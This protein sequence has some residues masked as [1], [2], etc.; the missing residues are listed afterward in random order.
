[1]MDLD[2]D[3]KLTRAEITTFVHAELQKQG[4]MT[5]ITDEEEEEMISQILKIEGKF[6]FTVNNN[7]Y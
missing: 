2:A 6:V 3:G 4:E 7:K 5:R 1:M